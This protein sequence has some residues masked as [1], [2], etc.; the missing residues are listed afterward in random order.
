MNFNIFGVVLL[1][2]GIVLMYA[3]VSDNDPRDVVK[4][5]LS[6]KLKLGLKPKATEK[7]SGAIDQVT[8]INTTPNDGTQVVSV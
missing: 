6:G 3:A 4:D 2:A 7:A 8:P 5:A 1:S